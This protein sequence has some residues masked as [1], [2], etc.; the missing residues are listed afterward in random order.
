MALAVVGGG[1]SHVGAVVAAAVVAMVCAGGCEE[2][3]I[4]ILLLGAANFGAATALQAGSSSEA[5]IAISGS[6][7]GYQSGQRVELYTAIMIARCACG[8]CEI[9][10]GHENAQEQLIKKQQLFRL[11][12]NSFIE[13]SQAI[14]DGHSGI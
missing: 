10:T 13:L 4:P 12:T 14:I 9:Y 1:D 6:L 11:P 5:W 3:I 7:G 2:V 8:G